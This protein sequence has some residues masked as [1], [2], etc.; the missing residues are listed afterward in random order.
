M[1]WI[2][3]RACNWRP[4]TLLGPETLKCAQCTHQ[5]G[6][7]FSAQYTLYGLNPALI[8][9]LCKYFILFTDFQFYF[10]MILQLLQHLSFLFLP[11]NPPKHSLPVIFYI[12]GLFHELLLHVHMYFINNI[13]QENQS[14]FH[15]WYLFSWKA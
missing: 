7:A 12:H 10:E 11:P 9:D 4:S 1:S 13:K 3:K 5:S 2:C 8:E 15:R 14:C 6:L